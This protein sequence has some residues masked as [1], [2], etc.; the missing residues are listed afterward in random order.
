[1]KKLIGVLVVA[2]LLLTGASAIT[3]D[4]R[5]DAD[6]IKT[7]DRFE[8]TSTLIPSDDSFT[9]VR[10][11]HYC[12]GR[13][14][15]LTFKVDDTVVFIKFDLSTVQYDNLKSVTL[16]L[17]VYSMFNTIYGCL[18]ICNEDW[19]EYVITYNDMPSTTGVSGFSLNEDWNSINV[20]DSFDSG[21]GFCLY[22]CHG[23]G[24]MQIHSKE[25][26]DPDYD[27]RPYLEFTYEIDDV[28]TCIVP[29]DFDTI[30]SAID[31]SSNGDTIFVRA[32]HYI[33][34]LNINKEVTLIGENKET[35][36]ID[37]GLT[38][39]I[40]GNN[41]LDIMVDNVKIEGFTI[42]KGADGISACHVGNI[43]IENNNIVNNFGHGIR[44]IKATDS[45]VKNNSMGKLLPSHERQFHQM[46][47]WDSHYLS[48]DN[49]LFKDSHCANVRIETGA[50]YI[51]FTDNEFNGGWHG[52]II[53]SGKPHNLVF[54]KNLFAN[55]A[56][57]ESNPL[58]KSYA[59]LFQPSKY[60]TIICNDFVNTSMD[61]SGI[62]QGV[63]FYDEGCFNKGNYWDKYT[64]DDNNHDGIGDYG[65][66]FPCSEG[67]D[68]YPLMQ[69]ALT[70]LK[71]DFN[72]DDI[73][74]L[75]DFTYIQTYFGRTDE[76]ALIADASG[77]G[78]VDMDD[79][80]IYLEEVG[81]R[82]YYC[83]CD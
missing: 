50:S 34:Q 59:I 31:A 17:H 55:F 76:V 79:Y 30:Q 23:Y 14:S 29:N 11:P 82:E 21:F 28:V 7:T 65:Y 2:M 61:V 44:L 57:P 3:A 25:E 71:C 10:V 13:E 38:H 42:T 32:G 75:A 33:E 51:T 6:I 5:T 37:G 47:I 46:S 81:K 53:G 24:T 12:F 41:V 16:N 26:F 63:T 72:D 27:F 60:V 15:C 40:N 8:Y 78:I 56:V 18:G 39:Y 69:S 77:N 48:I 62:I 74:N 49:N 80:N 70:V 66:W 20:T 52:V 68:K 22:P 54:K 83:N 58:G 64:G 4:K 1:M 45:V 36:I 73:V 67:F 35:T 19:D 9:L 43:T